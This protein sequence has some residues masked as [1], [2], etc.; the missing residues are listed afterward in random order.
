MMRRI[1]VVAV[2]AACA[3]QS[4]PVDPT[5]VCTDAA[6]VLAACGVATDA[7]PFGTCQLDQRDH[8][9]ELVAIHRDQGC[10][11]I[12]N[13]KADSFACTALPLLCV[14]H[15]V[16]ELASFSTDG[17]S[18]FPDGTLTD[19]TRWQHCCL[20]HDFAYYAG[21]PAE[22]R[23]TADAELRA[24]IESATNVLVADIVYYGVRIGGS[25]ALPTPWRWGYGWTYDPLDGYRTL[26]AAHAAAA[27]SRVAA[28]K[29]SPLPP[30]AFEQRVRALADAIAS[31]PGLTTAMDQ[32]DN[33]IRF[34]E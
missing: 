24:C 19:A 33:A 10:A 3:D 12:A 20:A 4:E 31:V 21:G 28:Y 9:D 22:L 11:A 1:I 17:C 16:A 13:A 5:Q 2:L 8:A 14:E 6:D 18:M 29:A 25:P 23:E 7:S 27:S 26:S 32:L 15:S 34:V 30:A